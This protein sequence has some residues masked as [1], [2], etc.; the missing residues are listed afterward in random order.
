MVRIGYFHYLLNSQN[1]WLQ[2]QGRVK[3]DWLHEVL[4]IQIPVLIDFKTVSWY[5]IMRSY[6]FLINHWIIVSYSP[7]GLSFPIPET[8]TKSLPKYTNCSLEKS[9]PLRDNI[10]SE[11]KG[12][13]TIDWIH[14]YFHHQGILLV[15]P[16]TDI[17]SKHM[18]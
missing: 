3:G 15:V 17:I 16:T 18:S 14:F 12:I 10:T 1:L 8:S 6:S 5:R 9:I 7:R 2:L 13:W 11:I 4:T